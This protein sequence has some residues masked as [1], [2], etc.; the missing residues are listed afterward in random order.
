MPVAEYS[1]GLNFNPAPGEATLKS[2]GARFF[3]EL[4]A[5]QARTSNI[6]LLKGL[7][8][9]AAKS[10]Q[11]LKNLGT[12][13]EELKRI[14][15]TLGQGDQGLAKLA[16]ELKAASTEIKSLEAGLA[17]GSKEFNKLT[18]SSAESAAAIAAAQAKVDGLVT[19]LGKADGAAAFK[20]V[21]AELLAADRDLTKLSATAEKNAAR[22]QEIATASQTANERLKVLRDSAATLADALKKTTEGQTGY[23]TLTAN[24]KAVEKEMRAAEKAAAN[25]ADTL[26]ALEA[27]LGLSAKDTNKLAAEQLALAAALDKAKAAANVQN[28]RGTLGVTGADEARA[29]IAKLTE[30]YNTL[31]AAEK[32][33]VIT[34]TELAVAK[35]NLNQQINT[36]EKSVLGTTNASGGLLSGFGRLVGGTAALT[37]AAT[38]VAAS[39]NAAKDAAVAYEQG[40]ARISSITTQSKTQLAEMGAEAL[41]LTAKIGID[42]PTALNALYNIISSGIPADNALQVLALSAKAAIAGVTDINTAATLGVA[43]LNAYG[44]QVGELDHVYDVLFQTVKDGVV[45]FPDLKNSLSEVLPVARTAG[46]SLEE[47]SAAMII[48][49]RNGLTAAESSTALQRTIQALTAPTPEAIAKLTALD[50]RYNGLL[51]TLRQIADKNLSSDILRTIIPDVRGERGVAILSRNVE[52]LDGFLKTTTNSLGSMK[53]AFDKLSDTPQ[54]KVEQLAA[55]FTA[56]RV[57]AGERLLPV[58]TAVVDSLKTVIDSSSTAWERLKALAASFLLLSPSGAALANDIA[59]TNAL[60][61]VFGPELVASGLSAEGAALQVNKYAVEL[62]RAQSAAEKAAKVAVVAAGEFTKAFSPV[63]SAV[64]QALDKVNTN[65][66]VTEKAVNTFAALLTASSGALSTVYDQQ[67]SLN[68]DALARFVSDTDVALAKRKISYVEHLKL[69][70]DAQLVSQFEQLGNLKIYADQALQI[71]DK[72]AQARRV[73]ALKNGDDIV[74]FDIALRDERIKIQ[75][76]FRSKYESH[77]AELGKLETGLTDLIRKNEDEKRTL[78]ESVASDIRSIARTSFNDEKKLQADLAL[79]QELRLKAD[80]ALAEGNFDLAKQY[81]SQSLQLSIQTAKQGAEEEKK[82]K[83]EVADATIEQSKRSTD[84]QIKNSVEVAAKIRE[85]NDA[86]ILGARARTEGS[87]AAKLAE[88]G[89]IK[90]LD[91]SSAAAQAA[92]VKTVKLKDDAIAA[93][94]QI[95]KTAQIVAGVQITDIPLRVKASTD[96]INT[97]VALLQK[98]VSE[99]DA[100]QKVKLSVDQALIDAQNL[101]DDIEKKKPQLVIE[102]SYQKLREDTDKAIRALPSIGL[103]ADP[104]K[105]LNTLIDVKIAIA[106]VG[107]TKINVQSNV[108]AIIS[109][110]VEANQL[111]FDKKQLEIDVTYNYPNGKPDLSGGNAKVDVSGGGNGSGGTLPGFNLGGYVGGVLR[112]PQITRAHV[113]H[114]A[115]GGQVGKVGGTG[116]TDSVFTQLPDRSFVLNPKSSRLLEQ[117]LEE[118]GF[119]ESPSTIFNRQRGGGGDN[120]FS[121]QRGFGGDNAFARNRSGGGDGIFNRIRNADGVS[122]VEG[123]VTD[124]SLEG[125]IAKMN[126]EAVFDRAEDM[127]RM[128]EQAYR[129]QEASIQKLRAAFPAGYVEGNAEAFSRSLS[130]PKVDKVKNEYFQARSQKSEARANAAT[131]SAI[132]LAQGI[133]I[134]ARGLSGAELTDLKSAEAA[135]NAEKI[136]QGRAREAGMSFEDYLKAVELATARKAEAGKDQ[137]PLPQK[138]AAGG[139]LAGSGMVDVALTPG[140]L[141]FHPSMVNEATLAQLHAMNKAKTFDH[142][143]AILHLNKGG[144]VGKPVPTASERWAASIGPTI[145]RFNAGGVVTNATTSNN[146]SSNTLN[147]PI[148]INAGANV[149][150]AQLARMVRDHIARIDNRSR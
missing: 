4:K 144:F 93:A 136:A 58:F 65:I 148:T 17:K 28:A 104:V 89:M 103:D 45:T 107:K 79:A 98:L 82:G 138:K 127:S 48:L 63:A 126:A 60:L 49:T 142:M 44:K 59:R 14:L 47:V 39:F 69:V 117:V 110:L 83:K 92:S 88:E 81:Y 54:Q 132:T 143:A 133:A 118:A 23:V 67:V 11:E 5:L 66:V 116:D 20:G 25:Q 3:A 123:G 134:P 113:E 145:E 31:H 13:A 111:R 75:A 135:D 40:L 120:A 101:K 33:G 38:A 71:F 35:R 2:F 70:S 18:A 15:G 108:D 53:S 42:L 29:Q 112:H 90:L 146:N 8:A 84:E 6:D 114:F 36:V 30:A 121:R 55:S 141:V 105:V 147:A 95:A 72:D 41:K 125:I 52:Q 86:A 16:A 57:A 91:Q 94:D 26:K 34:S 19:A 85:G 32:A 99:R 74:K 139:T 37:A 109:S 97:E 115:S 119:S 96:Q 130:Q 7:S 100:I 43:V 73:L 9:N 80:A 50:I 137:P 76:G 68:K 87:V 27:Q 149:N 150:E 122:G 22:L 61:K 62:E 24:L 77:V 64:G 106:D 129:L 140:E 46:I 128:F 78:K 131:S 56:L 10:E 124:G 1:I 21:R 12:R 51:G 102:A